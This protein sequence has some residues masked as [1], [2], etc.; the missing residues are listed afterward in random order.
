[1][2]VFRPDLPTMGGQMQLPNGGM[3]GMNC[4]HAAAA[5]AAAVGMIPVISD[6]VNTF[7]LTQMGL[8]QMNGATMTGPSMQAFG[9]QRGGR[10]SHRTGSGFGEV[11]YD[12]RNRFPQGDIPIQVFDVDT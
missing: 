5:A 9:P 1:M 6:G 11:G 3:M 2:Q 8:Q 4:M 10:V 12:N 7:Q